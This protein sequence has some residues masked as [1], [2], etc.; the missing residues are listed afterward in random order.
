[1]FIDSLLVGKQF[2]LD[3]VRIHILYSLDFLLLTIFR[4]DFFLLYS[5]EN[6]FMFDPFPSHIKKNILNANFDLKSWISNSWTH[7]KH[8]KT[9]F[10]D[11]NFSVENHP[12]FF[13]SN[14]FLML[15]FLKLFL[16]PYSIWFTET[17]GH[18]VHTYKKIKWYM[19][20][21]TT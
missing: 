19:L 5:M 11:K 17:L 12:Q 2:S 18:N 13:Y 9:I 21:R 15:F 4:K 16:N 8:H 20:V 6:R 3:F 7:E 1:M 10:I 14:K